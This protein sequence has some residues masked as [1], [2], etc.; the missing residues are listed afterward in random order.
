LVIWA[1]STLP[2]GRIESSLLA[3]FGQ[4]IEPAGRLLG[5]DWRLLVALLAS[6]IAKENS[7]AT[8]GVLYGKAQ[9]TSLAGSLAIA[10]PASTALAFLVVQMLFIPCVA[11][12]SAVRQETGS[13]RWTAFNLAFLLLVSLSA[14]TLVYWAARLAGL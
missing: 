6:F 11:T 9:S 1:L 2:D 13:W 10:Y 7:V 8:L 5:L 3:R 14:G 12:L 4:A